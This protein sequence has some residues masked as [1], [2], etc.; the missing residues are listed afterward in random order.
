[1]QNQSEQPRPQP[2][3]N[4]DPMGLDV[5]FPSFIFNALNETAQMRR[6]RRLL[7]QQ[8]A[9]SFL[10]NLRLNVAQSRETIAQ[11]VASTEMLLGS[12]RSLEDIEEEKAE[13]QSSVD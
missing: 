3:G 7:F 10:R 11:N 2:E 4:Q 5:D 13:V 1:M 6:N 12:R 9:R 8:N